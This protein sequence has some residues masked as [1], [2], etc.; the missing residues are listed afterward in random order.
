ML[1]CLDRMPSCMCDEPLPF[2]GVSQEA[3]APGRPL[4][5]GFL[6]YRDH[7]DS[8]RFEIVHFVTAAD[9]QEF[10]NKVR[11]ASPTCRCMCHTGDASLAVDA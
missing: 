11:P 5:V 1:A 10:K 4:R 7:C 6:G 3:M 2:F 9:V 8:D